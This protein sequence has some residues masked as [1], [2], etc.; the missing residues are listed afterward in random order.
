MVGVAGL[1][2]APVVGVLILVTGIGG[3]WVVGAALCGIFRTAV[4]AYAT[5][6]GALGGFDAADLS[7]AYSVRRKR[8]R[9]LRP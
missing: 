9:G 4:Y 2:L 3:L 6:Q 5:G 7:T 1:A 8:G